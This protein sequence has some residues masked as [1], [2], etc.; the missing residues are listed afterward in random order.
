MT[1]ESAIDVIFE[2]RELV[3]RQNEKIALLEK[4]VATLSNKLN[5]EVLQEAASVFSQAMKPATTVIAPPEPEPATVE[6]AAPPEPIPEEPVEQ[7]TQAKNIRAWGTLQDGEG[8]SVHGCDVQIKD[9]KD[10]LIKS[11]KS[12]RAGTW[13]AFLPPGQ[14]TA[15]FSMPGMEPEFRAFKLRPGQKEAEVT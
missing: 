1:E 8:K 11:T 3:K 14:Y 12:N 4:T 5:S 9:A 6:P 15:E 2:I 10:R 13:L 7:H